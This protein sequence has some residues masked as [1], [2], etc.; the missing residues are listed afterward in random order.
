MAGSFA[1]TL[2]G[3]NCFM[4]PGAA[5]GNQLPLTLVWCETEAYIVEQNPSLNDLS[6][7]EDVTFLMRDDVFACV[8]I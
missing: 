4:M 7:R 1:D 8:T 3:D 6:G 5:M 2:Q